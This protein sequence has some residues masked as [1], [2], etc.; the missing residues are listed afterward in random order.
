MDELS[1]AALA[2][3]PSRMTRTLS[4]ALRRIGEPPASINYDEFNFR[5]S[6]PQA[7]VR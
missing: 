4:R 6:W 7:S 5:W 3:G 2:A 1:A